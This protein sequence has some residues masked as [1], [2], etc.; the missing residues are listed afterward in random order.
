MK[1]RVLFAI[2][3]LMLCGH[4]VQAREAPEILTFEPKVKGYNIVLDFKKPVDLDKL[5]RA[6]AMHETGNCTAKVGSAIYNNCHG[7][8]TASGWLKFDDPKES[9][10]KFKSLW[11]KSY[12]GEMPDL[13]LATAYVC[14]WEYLEKNGA[15][16]YCEGGGS[17]SSWLNDVTTIY[18]KL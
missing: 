4:F 6:V 14:G 15:S 5:S 16:Q 2:A 12:G 8:K 9:H 13:R 10:E 7:F 1:R 18:N 11:I 3:C 17:P